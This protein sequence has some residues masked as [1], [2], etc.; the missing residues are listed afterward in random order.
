MKYKGINLLEARDRED[1]LLCGVEFKNP[2]EDNELSDAILGSISE[3][4]NGYKHEEKMYIEQ[5][6]EDFICVSCYEITFTK[7]GIEVL[8]EVY[9]ILSNLSPD[10]VVTVNV[11]VDEE[12]FKREDGTEYNEDMVS[13]EEFVENLEY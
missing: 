1:Q 10:I 3:S 2:N 4:F 5:V 13:W 7:E 6:L 8:K 9:D 11:H 12:W